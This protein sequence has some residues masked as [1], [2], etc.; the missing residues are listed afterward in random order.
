M[1]TKFNSSNNFYI[2]FLVVGVPFLIAGIY[3][4]YSDYQFINKATKVDGIVVDYHTG[5][6]RRTR[7]YAPVV[8]YKSPD[9]QTKLY[10][11]DVY[12]SPPMY[13]IDEKVQ[14]YFDPQNSEK[15]SMGYNWVLTG[16]FLGLGVIFTGLG[17][18]FKKFF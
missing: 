13:D 9:G 7:T 16:I 15:V 14:I 3:F 17:L 4:A 5:S 6:T 1:K 10:Y 11:H 12:S 8:E 2:W 18:L